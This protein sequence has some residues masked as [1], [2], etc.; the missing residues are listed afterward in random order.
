MD[1]SLRYRNYENLKKQYKHI[2]VS[3]R[4]KVYEVLDL[5]NSGHIHNINTARHLVN[6]VLSSKN[7]Q[8]E[9][10]HY[11]KKL[12]E[13]M[14]KTPTKQK[15]QQQ[16]INT[17]IG[18]RNKQFEETFKKYKKRTIIKSIEEINSDKA[19]SII[20]LNLNTQPAFPNMPPN[21]PGKGSFPIPINFEEEGI[22][23]EEVLFTNLK[24]SLV[25]AVIKIVKKF[26]K[27]KLSIKIQLDLSILCYKLVI[28]DLGL[29]Y[30][31]D[32]FPTSTKNKVVSIS[33]VDEIVNTLLSDLE[34]KIDDTFIDHGIEGSGWKVKQI[35]SLSI[36]VY[37]IKPSRGSSYI[38]TPSPYNNS[39]CGLINIQNDD[40]E[41]FKWCMKY[42]QS[43]QEKHDDRL[44]KLKQVKDKFD[45]TGLSYPVSFED[46]KIFENNN[47][48]SIFIYYIEEDNSIVKEKMETQNIEII[49]YIY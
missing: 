16:K 36:K 2:P 24:S 19:F 12:V 41:C 48:V 8:Q 3:K 11:Y 33:D 42:H 43:Q 23:H 10:L 34:H 1:K 25:D 18:T 40:E 20:K 14:S 17:R 44:S 15:N 9:N 5:Y 29:I 35:K 21:L 7:T 49:L 32:T 13:L 39:R 6:N 22:P 38:P 26:L 45:Y 31:Y 27:E 28:N 4:S 37:K 47:K 30:H 46:I